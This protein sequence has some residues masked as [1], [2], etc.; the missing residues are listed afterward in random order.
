MSDLSLPRHIS[1]S[2]PPWSLGLA[3]LLLCVTVWLGKYA[4][5][6]HRLDQ[7]REQLESK[8]GVWTDP[9]TGLMWSKQDN[10]AAVSWHEAVDY[11]KNLNLGG[12]MSW[13]MPNRDQVFSVWQKDHLKGGI[14]LSETAP[15]LWTSTV[16]AG[17]YSPGTDHAVVFFPYNKTGGWG[18]MPLKVRNDDARVLCVRGSDSF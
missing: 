11:C 6:H 3:V 7:Q 5:E 1:L 10:G 14:A 12:Y 18:N 9:A 13:R 8:A 15:Y 2:V 4:L 16:D 17:D